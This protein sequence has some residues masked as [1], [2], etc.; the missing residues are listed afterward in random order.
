MSGLTMILVW[1][2]FFGSLAGVLWLIA[3]HLRGRTT[4]EDHKAWLVA[5]TAGLSLGIGL[6]AAQRLRWAPDYPL[7]VFVLWVVAMFDGAA[8]LLCLSRNATQKLLGRRI[9]QAF[10]LGVVIFALWFSACLVAAD[11]YLT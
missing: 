11:R 10:G 6:S 2:V 9:F 3:S 8:A 7:V 1:S 4:T 5:A